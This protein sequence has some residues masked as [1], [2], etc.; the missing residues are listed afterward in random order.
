MTASDD[1]QAIMHDLLRMAR[2]AGG[3]EGLDTIAAILKAHQQ[4]GGDVRDVVGVCCATIY[5]WSN[6]HGRNPGSTH[7]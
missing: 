4:L 2:R 6:R 5:G 7:G 3:P 1:S